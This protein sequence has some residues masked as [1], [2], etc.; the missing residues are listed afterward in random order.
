MFISSNLPH[1]WKNDN[2]FYQN[3]KNLFVDVYV[4]HFKEDALKDGFFDLSEFS[5]IKKLFSRGTQGVLINGKDH[6]KIS[7][8]VKEVFNS[9]GVDRLILF[10]KTLDAI[11]K[12]EDFQLL[13]SLGYV[14][15]MKSLDTERLNKVVDFIMCKYSEEINIDEVASLANLTKASFCRYFKHRTHKTFSQFLNEVRILNASKLLI[16]SDKTITQICCSTGYN[17]ISHFNRQFKLIT[18]LTAKEFSKKYLKND[19]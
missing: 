6:K 13:S 4:I 10:L 15:N 12:T 14:N 8:L 18:G 7:E 16:T 11:A 3:N 9:T 2:D 5:H 17:N 1:V 19:I